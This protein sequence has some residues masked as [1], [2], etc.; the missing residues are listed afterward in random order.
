MSNKFKVLINIRVEQKLVRVAGADPGFLGRGF[1]CIKV[2][3]FALLFYLIFVKY[4]MNVWP[5][6]FIF[7]RIFKKWA[8]WRGFEGFPW[9]PSG[10]ATE[11]AK[12]QAKV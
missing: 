9:T 10:S 3:G 6:D 12:V 1:L 2:W 11:L 5:N 8:A 4:T 7:H